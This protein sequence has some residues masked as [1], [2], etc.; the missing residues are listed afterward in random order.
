MY[1]STSAPILVKIQGI[2]PDSHDLTTGCPRGS[3]ISP[4]IFNGLVAQLLI[5][6]L[7]LSV[8]IIAYA[9]DLV[10]ISHGSSPAHKLQ[11]ALNAIDNAAN[12][13]DLYF[14]QTKTKTMAFNTSRQS[15]KFKLGLHKSRN[16]Q[17]L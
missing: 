15:Q 2:N 6:T 9:D 10:L 17:Q 8:D 12:S 14:S 13:L 16:G 11:K 5:V 7:H 3:T 1:R 4:T